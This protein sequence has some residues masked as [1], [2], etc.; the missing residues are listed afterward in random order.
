MCLVSTF[1]IVFLISAP[2]IREEASDLLWLLQSDDIKS[3]SL[4][5]VGVGTSSVIPVTLLQFDEE[6]RRN[7]DPSEQQLTR[8]PPRFI[9]SA[10]WYAIGCEASVVVV[11]ID[12]SYLQM[13]IRPPRIPERMECPPALDAARMDPAEAEARLFTLLATFGGER[14]ELTTWPDLVLVD[15]G[16]EA[17]DS[18]FPKRLDNPSV[19]FG[20]PT[21]RPEI[22]MVIR[23]WTHAWP[24]EGDDSTATCS[25]ILLASLAHLRRSDADR[26]E[27]ELQALDTVGVRHMPDQ[28][29]FI[30]CGRSGEYL[31]LP[32][33]YV[34]GMAEIARNNV[35]VSG[36]P[37]GAD[38][39][40]TFYTAT[41][42][43]LHETS[44]AL[45]ENRAVVIGATHA[46]IRDMLATPRDRMAGALIVANGIH[47][48]PAALV[49][50]R[51]DRW[52]ALLSVLIALSL[53]AVR[54]CMAPIP[55][56]VLG[57]AIVVAG[58]I[59]VAS[60]FA[61]N[62]VQTYLGYA[63][64]A[65]IAMELC[66]DILAWM[67]RETPKRFRERFLSDGMRAR[68][69]RKKTP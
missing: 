60:L 26:F 33:A 51:N 11:D 32:I 24:S 6:T 21:L 65:F 62:A 9:L 43:R 15:A 23:R 59:G 8:T 5:E 3:V 52:L 19:M 45:F 28:P 10:L 66:K 36:V 56:I 54:A 68:H 49:S 14:G 27:R 57:F 55:A 63:A 13:P 69:T 37:I 41:L 48:A 39:H 4:S 46:D 29:G 18:G 2:I 61:V 58:A 64:L 7:L 35:R 17:W 50:V 16:A 47:G 30:D 31:Q 25:V 22:D 40:P 44:K 34:V 38:G 12:L 1:A 42:D 53:S 67:Q 20:S